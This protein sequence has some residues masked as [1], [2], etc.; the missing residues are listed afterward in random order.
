M[1]LTVGKLKK[2]LKGIDDKTPIY[3]SDH[4]HSEWETNGRANDVE[5]INQ[6]DFD[7]WTKAK[8]ETDYQFKIKGNYLVI[9]IG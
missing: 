4:D 2:L 1:S 5:L 7:D 6:D 8:L 9:R 3:L